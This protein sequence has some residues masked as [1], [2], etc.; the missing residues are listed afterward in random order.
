MIARPE[1]LALSQILTTPLPPIEWDCEPLIPHRRRVVVFGEFGALKS[2]ILLDIAL[3][4]AAG[5]PWLGCPVPTARRVLFVDEEMAEEDLRRRVSLLAH[6]LE[7][8]PNL[9]HLAFCAYSRIGL[10][11]DG[12][13]AR[14]LL[15]HLAT[16]HFDPEVI[17]VESFV[18]ALVGEENSSTDVREFW[19][20]VEPLLRAGKT[21]I[22]SHHTTKPDLL[23]PRP[24]RQRARGSGEILAG[25]D[26]GWGIQIISEGTIS[27][28]QCVKTRSSRTPQA[29]RVQVVDGLGCVRLVRATA[30]Q[31][32]EDEP[33][34]K[35]FKHLDELT[36]T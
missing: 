19:R 28:L 34:E 21:V 5:L 30:H 20:N 23:A 24:L 1:L 18:R 4:L 14:S 32:E 25:C 8:R 36:P 13:G 35:Q 22:V 7:P 6:G 9:A 12:F 3:H 33:N 16:A 2:W 31:Q 15:A 27:E 11:F 10:T 17:I 29:I 26:V